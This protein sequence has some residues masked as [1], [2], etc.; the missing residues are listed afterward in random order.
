MIMSV[1]LRVL[2]SRLGPDVSPEVA[3]SVDSASDELKAGISELR[4]LA[5]GIHP[6]VLTGEGLSGALAAL[7]E[8]SSV[9]VDVICP[10]LRFGPA[11]EATAYFVASEGLANIQKHASATRAWITVDVQGDRMRLEVRDDGQGGVDANKGSGVVGLADRLSVV[12]GHLDVISRRGR[13][14]TIEATI[15]LAAEPVAGRAEAG[16]GDVGITLSSDPAGA[17]TMKL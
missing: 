14:T 1:A 4:E 15:P 5:H 12:G 3:K 2:R 8:R 9:P 16:A 17:D 13:G 6:A 7:A 11:V 10:D